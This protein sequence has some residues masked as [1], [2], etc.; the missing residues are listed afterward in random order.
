[1]KPSKISME[2]AASIPFAGL[3][4]WSALNITGELCM[5]SKGK[6]VLVLGA[7]GGVGS[8]AVQLLKA[9]GSM[10]PK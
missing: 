2:E 4:A 9:W 7:S 10:V 8:I 1:M 5:G 6:K 3:T